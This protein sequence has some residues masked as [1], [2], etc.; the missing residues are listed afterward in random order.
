V[1]P[2]RDSNSGV[3]DAFPSF[4][5]AQVLAVSGAL[6]K[7]YVMPADVKSSAFEATSTTTSDADDAVGE[8]QII[9]LAET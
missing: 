1:K 8:R 5:T 7:V 2:L 3:V 9:R 4:A 6:V